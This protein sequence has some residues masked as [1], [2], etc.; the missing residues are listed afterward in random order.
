[1]DSRR[2][3]SVRGESRSRVQGKTHQGFVEIGI[4]IDPVDTD[5]RG[6]ERD[7]LIRDKAPI[8]IQCHEGPQG[9]GDDPPTAVPVQGRPRLGQGIVP[10]EGAH[11]IVIISVNGIIAPPRSLEDLGI[12]DGEVL[13]A[14]GEG[15]GQFYIIGEAK[16][17]I[18]VALGLNDGGGIPFIDR[19]PQDIQ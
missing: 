10:R 15:V 14:G 2:F 1:V 13:I 16:R 9:H 12:D 19:D 11:P 17:G 4:G 6:M 8:V 5:L 3:S 18:E 7:R